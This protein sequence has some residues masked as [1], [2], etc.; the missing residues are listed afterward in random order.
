MKSPAGLPARNKLILEVSHK[1]ISR[2]R[3]LKSCEEQTHPGGE[4]QQI[5]NFCCES[6]YIFLKVSM[7]FNHEGQTHPGGEPRKELSNSATLA[8]V[9]WLGRSG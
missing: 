3:T 1:F 9:V 6:T 7:C 4:P 5:E 2:K 8:S